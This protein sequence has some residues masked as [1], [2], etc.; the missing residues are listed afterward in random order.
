MPRYGRLELWQSIAIAFIVAV[1]VLTIAF[2]A[3]LPHG[4]E[5]LLVPIPI[6]VAS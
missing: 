1:V 2:Y 6:P 4:Q 5:H 3:F